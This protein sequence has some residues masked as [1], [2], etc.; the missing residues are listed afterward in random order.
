MNSH[1][2][3]SRLALVFALAVLGALT[4]APASQAAEVVFSPQNNPPDAEDGWQ[5]GTC[6]TRTCAPDSP[7]VEFYETAAGHPPFGMTQFIVRHKT[8]ELL[9][10]KREDPLVDMKTL[11]VDLPVGL[12][13]NP[14]AVPQCP[15]VHPGDCKTVAPASL[16]GESLVT[17]SAELPDAGPII[18]P[19]KPI[20]ISAPV[21]NLTPKPGQP[22]RFG[23]TVEAVPGVPAAPPSDIFLEADLAWESDFH[24]GFTI[25]IPKVEHVRLLKNRLIFDG[26]AGDPAHG[27]FIT[28]PSTCW[29][30][31]AP[32]FAHTY[33]TFARADSLQNPDPAFPTGSPY[34]ESALPPG[35]SPKG[36]ATIPFNPSLGADPGTKETDSPAGATVVVNLPIEPSPTGQE[37]STVRT[38]E[39]TLP[40]GMG[41]NPAAANGLEACTNEQFRKGQR[42]FDNA[43]PAASKVGTVSVASPHLPE[44]PPTGNVYVGEQLSN[45]PQSGD[46]FRI[47]VEAKSARYDVVVRL[48]GQVRANAQT[49]QLTA[50]F[51]DPPKVDALR[52]TLPEG[53]PQA[54]FTSFAMSFDGGP[55]AP[56]TSPPICGPHA[57]SSVLTPWSAEFSG[58]P[59]ATPSSEFT[60]ASAPGGGP[61]AKTLGER[62][63]GPS[64]AA[65]TTNPKGGAY[66][67]LNVSVSRADGNQELKGVNVELPPGMTAKLAGVKYCPDAAI[68][69]AAGRRG[70]AEKAQSSCPNS[71]QIGTASVDAGSGPSPLHIEGKVFLAG[72]YAGAPL[73]LAVITPATAG[74]FDLGTNVVRVATFVDPATAQIR[75][76]SDSIPHVF[77]GT[78]LNVRSVAVHVDRKQFALNPTNCSQLAVNGTM[79][80]GAGDPNNSAAFSSL[81]ASVP[82]QVKDCEALGFKPKLYLRLFGATKRAKNPKLRA[83]LKAREGDANISRAAVSLP[84]A[85]FLDQAS[86]SKVCTRPQF[87][88]DACPKGSMYGFA[89]AFS[90][91]LDQPLEGP[92]FLRSSDNEL[93]DLVAA[94]HGQI[95]ID[96]AGR[97]DTVRGGIRNTFDVIPDVPVSKFVL[98]M[99]GGKRGL[100]VNSRNLCGKRARVIARFKAQNGKKS[101]QRPKLRTPCKHYGKAKRS[102]GK[103]RH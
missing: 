77:G 14:G 101:N 62:P 55:K 73:S 95:D 48:V 22:A 56:L 82:F 8:S 17:V 61:C 42:V 92:V 1:A 53:L 66:S 18:V 30:P 31:T 46:Q 3:V 36:C 28:T 10:V 75:A 97:I 81:T 43:C 41:L 88:A 96:L 32:A 27:Y 44:G 29:D 74:P 78:L 47:L 76:V 80:G 69:S 86:L 21:Y 71:S 19:V 100:L 26:R 38:A 5:A 16:L 7:S 15:A 25:H 49:G 79:R 45:D 39:V 72:P 12:S 24:E 58:K 91:L 87:A 35:T 94:L 52:G 85:L 9:G 13:V 2:G 65:K 102:G 63:F 59:P 70:A 64:F 89:R 60:L 23:F 4:L 68:A 6:N 99:R 57:V 40:A 98:T 90:P 103:K 93:P 51:T 67:Q 11:R 37:T 54:P 20:T 84:H 34:V 83:V 50:R 33:S